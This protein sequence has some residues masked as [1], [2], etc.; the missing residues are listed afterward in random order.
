MDPGYLID[1]VL[2]N[3]RESTVVQIFFDNKIIKDI[4]NNY[5]WDI[6]RNME[7]ESPFHENKNQTLLNY[8]A[9]FISRTMSK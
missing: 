5:L 9:F 1:F 8:P 2:G 4:K 6:R 7:G 3:V